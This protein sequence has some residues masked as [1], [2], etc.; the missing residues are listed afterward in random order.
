MVI[1]RYLS[2]LLRRKLTVLQSLQEKKEFRVRQKIFIWCRSDVFDG[3]ASQV[4]DVERPWMSSEKEC[5]LTSFR[6]IWIR[7]S[8]LIA[9]LPVFLAMFLKKWIVDIRCTEFYCGKYSVVRNV[10]ELNY[11]NLGFCSNECRWDDIC[12]Q[13][14]RSI[15]GARTINFRCIRNIKQVHNQRRRNFFNFLK[16]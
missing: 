14:T 3:L 6:T 1:Y 16:D 10:N 12:I 11:R 4:A 13:C 9:T 5:K 15:R 7:L 2:Q 8:V